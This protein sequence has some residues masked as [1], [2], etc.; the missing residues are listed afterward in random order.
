RHA[1]QTDA[2]RGHD[3]RIAFGNC[4][5]HCISPS[6]GS[7]KVPPFCV[8]DRIDRTDC[9]NLV[10]RFSCEKLPPEQVVPMPDFAATV[11]NAAI[12][13]L[14]DDTAMV[15]KYGEACRMPGYPDSQSSLGRPQGSFKKKQVIGN[16][17]A[18]R[19]P[20]VDRARRL[21][22]DDQASGRAGAA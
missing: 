11:T 8:N 14:Y 10:F 4:P 19:N 13:R 18:P 7:A 22:A 3:E 9:R 12:R 20:D 5:D 17:D 15:A 2:D 16:S 1:R 21:F 6:P